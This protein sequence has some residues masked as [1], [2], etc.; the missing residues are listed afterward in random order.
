MVTKSRFDKRFDQIWDKIT[1]C[2]GDWTVVHQVTEKHHHRKPAETTQYCIMEIELEDPTEKFVA[3]IEFWY[4]ESQIEYVQ[5]YNEQM[6]QKLYEM[7]G[8]Y[9]PKV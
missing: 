6:R 9:Y 8:N 5:E 3:Y 4:E 1:A 7:T 2:A